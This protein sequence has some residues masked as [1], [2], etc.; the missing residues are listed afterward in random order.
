MT[1]ATVCWLSGP[2]LRA[3]TSARFH[4]SDAVLIGERRLL[5]EI[6]R[7]DADDFTE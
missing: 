3:R 4:V 2:V 5:G 6:I 7:V 1:E